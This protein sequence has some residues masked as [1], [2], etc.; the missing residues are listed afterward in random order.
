M[1]TKRK[2]IEIHY[3]KKEPAIDW[4][5]FSL[6]IAVSF[7]ILIVLYL[8]KSNF[9]IKKEACNIETFYIPSDAKLMAE[10][11]NTFNHSFIIKMKSVIGPLKF[12]YSINICNTTKLNRLKSGCI[13]NVL[14]K[15]ININNCNHEINPYYLAIANSTNTSAFSFNGCDYKCKLEEYCEINIK[16]RDLSIDWLSKNCVCSNWKL[17][18]DY[19]LFCQSS[20]SEFKCA[21]YIVVVKR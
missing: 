19:N 7:L 21:D 9:E 16:S 2:T 4:L 10:A 15:N 18:L 11:S 17:C 1:K 20:C 12:K 13:T 3:K 14:C 8:P 5:F 6:L